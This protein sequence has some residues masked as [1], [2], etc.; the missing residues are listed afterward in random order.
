MG[1]HTE[2]GGHDEG[3]L[4]TGPVPRQ[5]QE[6]VGAEPVVG[7][8][9]L[10]AVAPPGTVRV[11][12]LADRGRRFRCAGEGAHLIQDATVDMHHLVGEQLKE[13]PAIF[14]LR[15]ARD[16]LDLDAADQ[17]GQV[18]RFQVENSGTRLL[19]VQLGD[20][21]VERRR[22]GPGAAD[23]VLAEHLVAFEKVTLP[24]LRL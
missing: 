14:T 4:V 22:L 19:P 1:R 11:C 13:R 7:V 3:A 2:A 23:A 10:A 17:F 9:L 18:S 16:A 12:G 5:A 6:C 24:F 20:L 21:R 15:P 8:P